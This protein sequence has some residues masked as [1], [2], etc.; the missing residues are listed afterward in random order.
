MKGQRDQK[1]SKKKNA[2]KT[3]NICSAALPLLPKEMSPQS[4]LLQELYLENSSSCCLSSSQP[5]PGLIHPIL[6]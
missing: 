1:K 5:D 4:K 2:M 6:L 3:V